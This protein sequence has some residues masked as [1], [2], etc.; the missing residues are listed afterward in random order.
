MKVNGVEYAG[1]CGYSSGTVLTLE[2]VAKN[3]LYKFGSWGGAL[4]GST[5]PTKL[6]MDTSKTVSA[7]FVLKTQ[8]VTLQEAKALLDANRDV[9]VLDVSDAAQFAA[10]HMLCAK[11]YVWNSSSQTFTPSTS[12]L[13]AYK[14]MDVLIYDQTGT[15]SAGAASNLAG[16]G[17][18][19]VKYMTDGLDDWMAEGY[20]TFT[21]AE[22]AAVCTSLGPKAHAGSDQTVN[23]N[24]TVTLNGSGS[25]AGVTYA[26]EQVEGATVTFD[27]TAPN[28]TFIAPDMN[29][30]AAAETLVFHVTVT[31][32]GGQKDTD[33][34]TVTVRWNNIAPTANAGADQTVNFGAT[35]QLSGSASTDPEN[36]IVSYQWSASSGTINPALTGSATA[37]PSFTAPNK[38]GWVLYQLTVTDNGGLSGTDTVK[39]TVEEGVQ[40]E[41]QPPVA[42]ASDDQVMVEKTSITLNGS[43]TD[44]DG[45]IA[46]YKW[47]QT[48]GPAGVI[49]DSN[50]ASPTF[51]AP[52][53]T[54]AQ[55][56]TLTLTVTDDDGATGADTVVITINDDGITPPPENQPPVANAGD[57]QTMVEKT[58]ITLNGSG[59]DS[60][61]TIAS[62]Q[63]TQN[64][65]PAGV[66]SDSTAAAPTFT[67]PS[68][69]ATQQ[70]T[71][72]LTVTDDDGA[73]GTDTVV[74]TIND[75]GIA[76]PNQQP[77]ANAG[78]D[79][80][81]ESGETVTLDGSGSSD[82]DGTIEGYAWT[83]TDT[84]GIAV[85][86][87]GASTSK[88][89]F[90]APVVENTI[91][92]VFSLTVTD[93][94]GLASSADTVSITVTKK[95]SGGGGGGGG[96]F[97]N[98]VSD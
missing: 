83:Q 31:D 8:A 66:I 61:G 9:L 28:P 4:S 42:N 82:P 73:T 98:S 58:S 93:N 32:A 39:V 3:S 53:V 27:S 24:Q 54:V 21:T 59:T 56:V 17:F 63:W 70:V 15:K 36:N 30:P 65:G 77:A 25:S 84:T 50:A 52:S 19:S 95:S 91:T 45:T 1:G 64:A 87:T 41:N 7:T 78:L 40:P 18:S 13:S 90:M 20:E 72:T 67:A 5:N 81:V 75:D 60:D 47:T 89:S 2:A 68:V 55:Q 92:L 49:S 86:L 57:D 29:G 69:T 62:Y 38:A 11:N 74:V 80:S 26:W 6:T 16:Q 12:G 22:D 97:I 51:T 79:Q 14:T 71:L 33:S 10:S 37:T 88:P 96:C 23:E 48:G 34:V 85:T 94:K 76:P 46:S 35:V 43:G 44:S